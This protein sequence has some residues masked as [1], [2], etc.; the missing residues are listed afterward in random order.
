M[1]L[2]L[3]IEVSPPVT[4][5]RSA[6]Q[7]LDGQHRESEFIMDGDLLLVLLNEGG[8]R[9]GWE[10]M[11]RPIRDTASGSTFCRD[12][13]RREGDFFGFCVTEDRESNRPR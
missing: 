5:F 7:G 2:V 13:V 12:A 10:I 3:D 9:G 4:D 11:E 8:I 6:P 1:N